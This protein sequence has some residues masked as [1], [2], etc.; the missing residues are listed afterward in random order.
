MEKT[1]QILGL[2]I[3]LDIYAGS[4]EE[5]RRAKNDNVNTIIMQN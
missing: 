1:I 2:I 3:F 4:E 5:W